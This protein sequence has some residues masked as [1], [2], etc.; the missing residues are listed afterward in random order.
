MTAYRMYS[1]AQPGRFEISLVHG[2]TQQETYPLFA[3]QHYLAK[4]E[5][6]LMS[7]FIYTRRGRA[8]MARHAREFDVVHGLQGFHSTVVPCLE[9]QKH[10]VPSVVKFA[11][12]GVE[13]AEKSGVRGLLKM[14]TR[15]RAL[16]AQLSGVIAISHDIVE[17]LLGYGIPEE[18]IAR[19]PNGVDTTAFAP[20]VDDAARSALR[21]ELG[22]NDRPTIVFVGA[23][24]GRKRSHLL[25]EAVGLLRREGVD[26]QL[27]LAGPEQ[28]TAYSTAMRERAKSLDIVDRVIWAGFSPNVAPIYRAGDLFAL[29]SSS[30]GLPNAMLEAMASGL[31]AVGTRISGIVDL[32]APGRTGQLVEPDPASIAGALKEFVTDLPGCRAAG[33]AAREFILQGYSVEAVLDAHERLFRGVMAGRPA[34]EAGMR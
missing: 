8:W 23:I 6:K 33:S 17:E 9:A 34:A 2:K 14:A 30:E 11:V 31:P 10:G 20:P 28:D 25:V 21:R 18:R 26:C 13:L 19:I 32:I 22:W 4:S 7:Q 24:S 12:H 27:V 15:R 29:P 1:R 3:M 16:V 5:P